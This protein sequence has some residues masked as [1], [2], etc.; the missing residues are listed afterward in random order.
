M[1]SCKYL[2]YNCDSINAGLAVVCFII[3]LAIL[4]G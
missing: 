4:F 2:M 3:L 1:N